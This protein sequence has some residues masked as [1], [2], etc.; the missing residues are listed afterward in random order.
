MNEHFV[1]IY[2]FE[3]LRFFLKGKFFSK[4]SIKFDNYLDSALFLST[5]KNCW[6]D[7]FLNVF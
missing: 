4:E 7:L 6:I 5:N 3:V 1:N 2:G